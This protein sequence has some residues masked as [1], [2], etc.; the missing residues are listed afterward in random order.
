MSGWQQLVKEIVLVF[1][2]IDNDSTGSIGEC[3]CGWCSPIYS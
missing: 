2:Y 1:V 3:L